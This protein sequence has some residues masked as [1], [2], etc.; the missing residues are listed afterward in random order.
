MNADQILTT[1]NQF[2][3]AYLLIGGMN[4]LLRHEPSLLT[5][6][7]DLWIENTPE[8][9]KRCESAL[10]ALDA[11]WGATDADWGPVAQ[12]QS[13]WLDHSRFSA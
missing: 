9:R 5:Y 12:R 2:G 7:V 10:A 13:G 3:V 4:F 6:D 11:E 8:N 1:M